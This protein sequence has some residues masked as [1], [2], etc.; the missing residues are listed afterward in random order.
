MNTDHAIEQLLKEMKEQ[1]L[2]PEHCEKE[3]REYLYRVGAVC[4]EEGRKYRSNCTP[5]HQL[6]EYGTVV[7]KWDSA[8]EAQRNTGIQSTKIIA[9]CKGR[10][11]TAGGYIWKH[12]EPIN[13]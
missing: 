2:F 6:N 12:V 13:K 9:V 11:H 7:K 10:A 1:E 5:V 3:V 8:A 4:F